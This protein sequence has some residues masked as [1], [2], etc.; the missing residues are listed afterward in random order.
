LRVLAFL[1]FL[2]A[3]GRKCIPVGPFLGDGSVGQVV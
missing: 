3:N 1:C 2:K